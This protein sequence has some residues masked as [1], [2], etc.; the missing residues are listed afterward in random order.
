MTEEEEKR[1]ALLA[2]V[3]DIGGRGKKHEVLENIEAKGYLKLDAHDLEEM[4]NRNEL[5]WRNDIAYVRHH[6]VRQRYLD[7]ARHNNWEITANGRSYFQRLTATVLAERFFR[8]L[9]PAAVKRAAQ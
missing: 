6:L 8:K 7:G 9:T 3:L 1:F 4:P 5:F 2:S